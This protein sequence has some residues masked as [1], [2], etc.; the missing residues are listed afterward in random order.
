MIVQIPGRLYYEA[1]IT[2]DP[3]FD[4]RRVEAANTAKA[5]EFRLA[6]LIMRKHEADAETPS[7]DDTFMTGHSKDLEDLARRTRE[8]CDRLQKRGYRVRRY[9]IEDTVLDSRAY[10]D[11]EVLRDYENT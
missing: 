10:D 8:L 3:V 4:D 7:Q 1:H 11:F 9:K 5:L 2:I 6:N